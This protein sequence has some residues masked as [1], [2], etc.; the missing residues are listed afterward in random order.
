LHHVKT[1]MRAQKSANKLLS[2]L[3]D[4]LKE[5]PLTQ[6]GVREL[7]TRSGVGRATF[8]RNFDEI[9]D[10][11]RWQS[12]QEIKEYFTGYFTDE[13][14]QQSRLNFLTYTFSYWIDHPQVIEALLTNGRAD[15]I[16][17][18]FLSNTDILEEKLSEQNVDLGPI[19]PNVFFP[20][21]AG[22]FLGIMDSWIRSGKK[23]TASELAR[24]IAEQ[25]EY[26]AANNLVF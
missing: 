17:L 14:A 6:I 16:Y 12:D 9:D 3:L 13:K 18:G 21:R 24:K 22:Y 7:T 15:I 5:K 11:L 2:T 1:D 20:V 23:A 25:E 10:I 26:I 4:V 8:Y 19:D